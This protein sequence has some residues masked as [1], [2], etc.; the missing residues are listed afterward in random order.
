MTIW[1]I[2]KG[3]A[4]RTDA[5]KDMQILVRQKHGAISVRLAISQCTGN[6]VGH[7]Y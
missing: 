3:L 5:Q 6:H 2:G 1:Y 4:L 7:G